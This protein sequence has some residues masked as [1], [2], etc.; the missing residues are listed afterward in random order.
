MLERV[1]EQII[2]SANEAA[3]DVLLEVLDRG[4]LSERHRA[5]DALLQRHT[6]TGTYGLLRRLE[7]L[8]NELRLVLL[9]RA[10]ELYHCL[11][12]AG[13]SDDPALRIAAVRL[14]AL[15]RL[16]RLSYVLSENLYHPDE[17]VSGAAADALVSLSRHIA[18]EVRRLQAGTIETH[19][20]HER[21]RQ[22]WEMRGDIESAVNRALDLH[23]GTKSPELLR[24]ALLLCDH[25]A[26]KTLSI[27]STSR[28]G[29][30][31]PMVKR[32]Q[33]SPD[34]EHVDAFLLGATHGQLRS[35]FAGAFSGI[36]QGPVLDALLRRVY[37]LK[38]H[39]MELC[40]RGVSRGAWWAEP[41]LLKDLARREPGENIGIAEFLAVSG[42]HDVVQDE[43][44]ARVLEAVHADAYSRSRMLAILVKRP[45][46]ASL[47]LLRRFLDDPDEALQ[48]IAAREIV[49]RRP[50]DASTVLLGLMKTGPASVRRVASRAISAGAFDNFYDRFDKLDAP[51]RL[52]AGK[53]VFKLLPDALLRLSRKLNNGPL[54]H[55]LKALQVAQELEVVDLLRE[56]ILSLTNAE[57]AKLRSKAVLVAGTL[58]DGVPEV[59]L[60]KALSDPD[61]RVRA[62]AIE[63]LETMGRRDFVPLLAQRARS[64]HNRERANAIKALVSMKVEAASPQ[65]VLMLRDMRPEHRISALWLVKRMGMFRLLTEIA[66]LAR[67]ETDVRVK[68]YA[69]AAVRHV[70]DV[71]KGVRAEATAQ[72]AEATAQRPET[73]TRVA[74][75]RPSP[76]LANVF[77]PQNPLVEKINWKSLTSRT[78]NPPQP[79][80]AG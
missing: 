6:I 37:F 43:K 68:R 9:Q 58:K 3:D 61:G 31:S 33:Q 51:T 12:E 77:R 18:G 14:I 8:P 48:R 53:A 10:N 23:K 30:V 74:P 65:L 11:P 52:R 63:V 64:A 80:K 46:G 19:E 13:R 75:E 38:D 79:R 76:G 34:A 41:A 22:L 44:L 35:Q 66:R 40:M 56:T 69:T 15:G 42:T 60:E 72:Q 29:G 36:E 78:P 67:E 70:V 2:A 55:R 5:L 25:P 62:N 50:A 71:L 45:R 32:L 4:D 20:R 17:P 24:A 16:G 73:H 47:T 26:S 7:S 39:R 28:H 59:L 57:N 1:L 54:D 27:L 21:H 49:R